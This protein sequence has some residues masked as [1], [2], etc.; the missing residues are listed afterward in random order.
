MWKLYNVKRK[1]FETANIKERDEQ[2]Y[3]TMS[4]YFSTDSEY[5]KI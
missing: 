2:L 5:K 1:I 4:N 3:K